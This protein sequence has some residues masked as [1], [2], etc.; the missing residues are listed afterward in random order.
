MG[1]CNWE[2]TETSPPPLGNPSKQATDSKPNSE[3]PITV[4]Y[5]TEQTSHHPPVSAYYIYCP[6][7]GISGRG[8]DQ[9]SANFT[10]TR[11]RVSP[12][13]H[14]KGIYITLHN[15]DDESYNL[16]HP[17]AHLGGML[18]G[19]LSVSVADTC[20]VTCPKTRLKAIL[21][22]LEEGWIGKSQ[23]RMVGVIFK[24]D[25]EHDSKTRIKDVADADIIARVEGCWHEQIYFTKGSK[26]FDK[27]VSVISPCVTMS[28]MK[29]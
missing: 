27:S 24:Y 19:N 13:E 16:T 23:N 26:S 14:N 9:L 17:T 4:S 8:F 7:K 11:V 18:R 1:Q 20:Y 3:N 25:P 15:F 5:F 2:I 21:Q 10:G 29:C 6:E 22:Y 12:G 28:H